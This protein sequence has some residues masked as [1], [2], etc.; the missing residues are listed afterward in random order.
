MVQ[1][2]CT[3]TLDET[4]FK[5]GISLLIGTFRSMVV[6]TLFSFLVAILLSLSVLYDRQQLLSSSKA[7][8]YGDLFQG[9][10]VRKQVNRD[11]TLRKA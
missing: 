5:K 6:S 9:L 1:T 2:T 8:A 4:L 11:V 7:Q 3:S 10:F